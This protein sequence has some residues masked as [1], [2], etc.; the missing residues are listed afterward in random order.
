MDLDRPLVFVDTETT[1]LDATVHEVVEVAYSRWDDENVRTLIVPHTLL[2]A[3]PEALRINRYWERGLNYRSLWAQPEDFEQ[4]RRDV[5]GATILSAN[6]VFDLGFLDKWISLD[7]HYRVMDF[8]SWAAGRLGWMATH[9]MERTYTEMKERFPQTALP[10]PDHT[11]A[12][13]VRSMKEMHRIL[14]EVL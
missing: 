4:F 12:G 8:T 1:G 2:H 9:G 10:T 13:D 6:V 3:D 14:M 11:A 7:R 5:S